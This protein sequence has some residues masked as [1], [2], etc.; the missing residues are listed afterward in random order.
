M[1]YPFFLAALLSVGTAYSLQAETPGQEGA[2]DPA[3]NR[4]LLI[5]L[6]IPVDRILDPPGQRTLL[7]IFGGP[8]F[9]SHSGTFSLTENG[10]T[11]C[12]F[13]EGSGTGIAG[14]FKAF[15]P[16]TDRIDIT[17]RASYESRPGTFTTLS[18]PLPILGE[19]NQVETMRFQ[20]ELN[21]RLAGIA[22]DPMASYT[23]TDFGLYAALGPSFWLAASRSFTVDE[24]IANPT[25][26]EYK[27][28]GTSKRVLEGDL[29]S[30]ESVQ[31]GGRGGIGARIDITESLCLNPEVL[32]THPFTAVTSFEDWRTAGLQLTLGMLLAL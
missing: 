9:A 4:P 22:I 21:V 3:E 19:N 28:G 24:T 26:V 5:P 15:I 18:E 7:G 16:L 10:I 8:N 1:R 20:D 14:G 25:G 31:I 32:Y 11:C 23:I 12:T 17:P 6:P 29:Q 27:S 2:R 13:D 30:T